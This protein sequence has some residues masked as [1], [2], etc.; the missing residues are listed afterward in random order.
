MFAVVVLGIG[1]IMIAAMFPVALSQ[2]KLTAD[3]TVAATVARG[4]VG[5]LELIAD[6]TPAPGTVPPRPSTMPPTD[7][8]PGAPA[9]VSPFTAIV[10]STAGTMT[11]PFRGS[12]EAVCGSL[13][14]ANDPRF[15][16]VPLYRRETGSQTAQVIIIVT[17]ARARPRY[18]S[19]DTATPGTAGEGNLQP[20]PVQVNVLKNAGGTGI[21]WIE[22]SPVAAFDATGAV[23]EGTYVVIGSDPG[24]PGTS[25]ATPPGTF[26]GRIY[27]LGLQATETTGANAGQLVPNTWTF[28]PGNEYVPHP[29]NDGIIGTT[30]DW[31][32]GDDA[33]AYIV[34]REN[35][36]GAGTYT[37]TAQD[38]SVYSTF[39][40]VKP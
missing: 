22:F 30:D 39:I 12:W 32:I 19:D 23:A 25:P 6:D 18:T 27:R 3:E 34:G 33:I 36:G 40:T 20:R 8:A 15:A 37:G 31:E 29:G 7:T 9:M 24:N 5:Y 4:A 38:V 2:S 28:L 1:F 13:I 17:Q 16:F 26:N 11:P 14:L 21:H 10:D 35:A